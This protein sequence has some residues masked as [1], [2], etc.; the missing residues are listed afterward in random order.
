MGWGADSVALCI[1][2][3]TTTTPSQ[4]KRH[5][6]VT[7]RGQ[8]SKASEIAQTRG[9]LARAELYTT[10]S[11]SEDILESKRRREVNGATV[12]DLYDTRKV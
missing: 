8:A 10:S 12:Y 1:S 7:M 11:S 5:G 3:H 2:T 4:L 9:R 6:H